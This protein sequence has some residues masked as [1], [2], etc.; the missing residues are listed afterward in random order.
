MRRPRIGPCSAL[1][2]TERVSRGE[3]DIKFK[4]VDK[5]TNLGLTPPLAAKV[6]CQTADKRRA[7]AFVQ[8]AY[9]SV[10]YDEKASRFVSIKP[11]LLFVKLLRV[12]WFDALFVFG[13][14]ILGA[15]FGAWQRDQRLPRLLAAAGL[16]AGACAMSSLLLSAWEEQSGRYYLKLTHAYV[17]TRLANDTLLAQDCPLAVPNR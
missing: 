9:A 17:Q 13:S 15:L 11:E 7:T 10:F 14:G 5:L 1:L 16:F 6:R 12:L 4:Q 8:H 3:D 2:L